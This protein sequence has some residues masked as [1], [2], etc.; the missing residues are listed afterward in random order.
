MQIMIQ[1]SQ[2]V[3]NNLHDLIK[4]RFEVECMSLREREGSC[5]IGLHMVT[6]NLAID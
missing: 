4:T 6:V 2:R 5:M 3:F 1:I